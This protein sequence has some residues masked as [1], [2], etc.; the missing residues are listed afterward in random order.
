MSIYD[1]KGAV[2]VKDRAASQKEIQFNLNLKAGSYFVHIKGADK[3]KVMQIV[4][5][6]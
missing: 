2:I 5:S 3:V 6:Q 4:V 1:V